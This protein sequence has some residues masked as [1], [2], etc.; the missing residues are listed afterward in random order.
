M[1]LF[2]KLFIL[3]CISSTFFSF[4]FLY[5][6]K[7]FVLQKLSNFSIIATTSNNFTGGRPSTT[8]RKSLGN[9]AERINSNINQLRK[10][11]QPRG[12][13]II[14]D[15]LSEGFDKEKNS[16]NIFFFRRQF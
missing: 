14:T 5:T 2:R 7:S 11:G 16:S 13:P 8:E 1:Y 3:S 15:T 4:V 9:T 10:T 6:K 12:R